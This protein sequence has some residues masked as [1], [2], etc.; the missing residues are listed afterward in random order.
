MCPAGQWSCVPVPMAFAV[1]NTLQLAY[2]CTL[3][4]PGLVRRGFP[5]RASVHIHTP[6]GRCTRRLPKRFK[7]EWRYEGSVGGIAFQQARKQLF[8]GGG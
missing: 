1:S 3:S 5:T 8:F 4:Y 2:M 6:H 7:G